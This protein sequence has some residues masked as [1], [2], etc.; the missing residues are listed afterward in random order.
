[1]TF[2]SDDGRQGFLFCDYGS[3]IQRSELFVPDLGDE[4][5]EGWVISPEFRDAAGSA[6]H[7]CPE[8]G[9]LDRHATR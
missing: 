2:V 1:M 4:L 3:C 5:P 6:G 8:H 9:A 7:L